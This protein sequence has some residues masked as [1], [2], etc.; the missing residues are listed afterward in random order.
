[1][2]HQT[3]LCVDRP[4]KLGAKWT[5]KD[6]QADEVITNIDPKSWDYKRDR[7]NGYD[8][9]EHDKV[10]EEYEK[11]EEARRQLKAAELD[12]EGPASVEE[13]KRIIEGGAAEMS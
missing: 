13:A 7:W 12:K 9:K 1:M 6:I 10:I 3:K 5:G 4:R 2:S 8:P 11:I